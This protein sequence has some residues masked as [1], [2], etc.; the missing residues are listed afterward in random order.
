[1]SPYHVLLAPLGSAAGSVAEHAVVAPLT[2]TSGRIWSTIAILV[3]AAA[4]VVGIIA[5]VR[6]GRG[7][8]DGRRGAIATVVTGVVVAVVGGTVVA[9][10]EGGPGTGYGI[11]GGFVSLVVA[12]IAIVLGGLALARSRPART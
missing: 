8:G 7:N 6:A 5:L 3:G 12:L 1:M 4:I 2:L 10:A 11:V 9:T